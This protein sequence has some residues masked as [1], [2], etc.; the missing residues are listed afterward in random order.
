MHEHILSAVIRGD[1]A[2]ALRIIKPFHRSHQLGGCGGVGHAARGARAVEGSRCARLFRSSRCINFEHAR[3]LC[4]LHALT[5]KHLQLGA[6]GDGFI[7]GGLKCA[8][9]EKRIACAIAEFDKA[10]ALVALEPFHGGVDRIA[11]WRAA[12]SAAAHSTHAWHGRIE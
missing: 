4:A 2:E 9:M 10:E 6:G 3:D 7:A 12:R 5:D 8:D 1:K 11:G